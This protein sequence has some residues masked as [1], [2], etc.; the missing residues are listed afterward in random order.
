[1][2]MSPFGY[3]GVGPP[4]G[5]GLTQMPLLTITPFDSRGSH[6]FEQAGSHTPENRHF[7]FF[8]DRYR[9]DLFPSPAFP[10]AYDAL[11]DAQEVRRA[12]VEYVRILQLAGSTM[13]T[14]VA[15]AIEQLRE[16]G[17]VPTAEQVRAL[18][19]PVRPEVRGRGYRDHEYLLLK[20]QKA[21]ATRRLRQT[22]RTRPIFMMHGWATAH[23]HSGEERRVSGRA[24]APGTR[25]PG[26][27]R[28]CRDPL[29]AISSPAA[30]RPSRLRTPS[31]LS[32][33]AAG[34]SG[35]TIEA[36]PAPTRH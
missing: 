14:D 10:R 28:R 17:T 9:D 21:T 33:R 24:D 29:G 8:H 5:L 1:M 27:R 36:L 32:P 6:V 19:S 31:A 13:E 16:A 30:R 25:G 34:A 35:R 11:R 18:A 26:D 22:A 15:Q 12:E 7:P 20:V 3:G 23:D 4:R 2:S